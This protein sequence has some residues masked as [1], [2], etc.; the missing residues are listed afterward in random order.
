MVTA[1]TLDRQKSPIQIG[2]EFIPNFTEKVKV[3]ND[4]SSKQCQVIGNNSPHHADVCKWNNI[5][6]ANVDILRILKKSWS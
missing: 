1:K 6:S 2:V 3:F 4:D 5:K